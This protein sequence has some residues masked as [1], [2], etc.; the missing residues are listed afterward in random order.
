[1]SKDV[2]KTKSIKVYEIEHF[3]RLGTEIKVSPKANITVNKPGYKTEF[4]TE[5]IS[6]CIGIGKDHTADLIMSKDAWKALNKGEEV[7]ITTTK[8]FKEKY[9]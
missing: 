7:S 1:M 2:K 6:V 4:F 5:T 8:A 9:L 3:A